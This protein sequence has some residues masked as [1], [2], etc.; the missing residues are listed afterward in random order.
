[1]TLDTRYIL[2]GGRSGTGLERT[3]SRENLLTSEVSGI[4]SFFRSVDSYSHA[5]SVIPFKLFRICY[6]ACSLFHVGRIV[7]ASKPPTCRG[8]KSSNRTLSGNSACPLCMES[9]LA[10]RMACCSTHTIFLHV[11]IC[12][13]N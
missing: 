4:Y 9:L 6:L 3:L 1:M 8:S 13:L 11:F 2:L 12:S 5:N 7:W 10:V